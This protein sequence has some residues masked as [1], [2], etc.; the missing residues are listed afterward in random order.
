MTMT[1]ANFARCVATRVVGQD[2]DLL[3]VAAPSALE[4]HWFDIRS[5][6]RVEEVAAASD[7]MNV[8]IHFVSAPAPSTRTEQVQIESRAETIRSPRKMRLVAPRIGAPPEGAPSS[9]SGDARA[10]TRMC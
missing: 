2:G 9:S 7:H 10:V 5:R 4:L 1:P 8:R 6:R 3:Q